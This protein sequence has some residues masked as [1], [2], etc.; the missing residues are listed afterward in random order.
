M[1]AEIDRA[2]CR[3]MVRDITHAILPT[4]QTVLAR[5]IPGAS[6]LELRSAPIPEQE[7]V[8]K[9]GHR[10]PG[11][12]NGGALDELARA[13]RRCVPNG[14]PPRLPPTT[15]PRLPPAPPAQE[16]DAAAAAGF[17][18]DLSSRFAGRS[19]VDSSPEASPQR[20]K[21]ALSPAARAA[22][23]RGGSISGAGV[24]L[25]SPSG[26]GACAACATGTS[27]HASPRRMHPSI[28]E[29]VDSEDDE[30]QDDEALQLSMQAAIAADRKDVLE[31][32]LASRGAARCN[33]I[34]LDESLGWECR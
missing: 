27:H 12:Q 3:E 20:E 11:R 1:E 10:T 23:G 26:S 25:H 33:E 34:G 16:E 30:A 18:A 22:G 14:R 32:L 24:G 7:Q 9:A 21:R 17:G 6:G 15:A 13:P 19:S 31:E 2:D 4:R 8:P 28:D 5:G 29:D